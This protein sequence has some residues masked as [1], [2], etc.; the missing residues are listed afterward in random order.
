MFTLLLLISY[1][2]KCF[3]R[4]SKSIIWLILRLVYFISIYETLI[5]CI[6]T[7]IPFIKRKRS[8][9]VFHKKT[10]LLLLVIFFFIQVVGRTY[11]PTTSLLHYSLFSAFLCS[12][13]V[14]RLVMLSMCALQFSVGLPR[15]FLPLLLMYRAKRAMMSSLRI[16]CPR[17]MS[18]CLYRRL[19]RL[20]LLT[21]F[22]TSSFWLYQFF[23]FLPCSGCSLSQRN[24]SLSS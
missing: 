6:K 23:L 15:R 11:L 14:V 10:I 21:L 24:L 4:E 7:L 18:W 8:C 16:Q 9:N 13:A 2:S 5:L 20:F 19:L 22:R 12:S 17:D 1:V 3:F